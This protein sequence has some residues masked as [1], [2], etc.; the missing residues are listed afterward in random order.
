MT[1][2]N[3]RNGLSACEI[4][5]CNE[6]WRIRFTEN[7]KMPSPILERLA[8]RYDRVV[9]DIYRAGSGLHSWLRPIEQIAD[10]FDAWAV[11]L[12]GVNK[13]T[14]VMSFSFESGSAPPAGPIEYLRHYHRIDPRLGKFL[15]AQ[16]G[17]WFACEE[18]FD[19][20]FV[21]GNPFY[22]DYL[23]PLGARYLYGTKL[24]D[25]E[26]ATVL[27][28]HLSRVGNPPLSAAE[29]E[30]FRRISTHF[31]KALDIKKALEANA[32]RHSVGAELLEKL[33]QPMLLIDNERRI[34]YRNH[35]ARALLG[36]RDLVF[37]SEGLLACR[38]AD[39][40]LDLTIAIRSLGLVPISTHGDQVD[41]QERRVVRLK[42]KD[43]GR[44]AGTLI[45]LRPES[46]MGSFGPAPQALF[47]VFEPGAPVDIDPFILSTT[48]DLTPAE[49]RVAAAIVA[50]GSPEQCARDLSVKVSTVRSHLV[51]IYRKTG[52]TGQADLVR[53]ILSATT[54]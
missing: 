20:A 43:G 19:D 52:A 27:L 49:A 35:S 8:P 10:I 23:I 5:F 14:G 50:G 30:A 21:A 42:R 37:D 26:S 3:R 1:W 16:V 7:N 34:T 4:A 18:H 54:L 29:K 17:D 33:R 38:D 6:E 36:R 2:V 9:E 48:F 15:P 47:T 24:H 22:Q 31:Q 53:L 12:L 28:G 11:Q 51:A 45:A 40:D 13:K 32:D 46:T 25:D 39:S 41:L 44:V